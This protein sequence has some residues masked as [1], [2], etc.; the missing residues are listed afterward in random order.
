MDREA[1]VVVGA[2]Q[3]GAWAVRTLRSHGF[4]GRLVL[5]GD[6][7]APPYERPP[8]SKEQLQATP[9]MMQ[10]LM[11][12]EELDV[13]AIEWRPATSCTRIDRLTRKVELSNG[14]SIRYDQLILCT[15]GRARFPG[16][17]GLD[18]DRVHTLR[19]LEDAERLHAQL[20]R[21]ARLLVIGG[22]WIGL[23]VAASARAVGCAVTL[24]EAG[25]SLCT[26][27]GSPSLSAFLET[28]HLAN[29][30][31]LRLGTSVAAL[32]HENGACRVRFADGAVQ[33]TDIVVVGVG[34]EPNDALARKAGLACDRGILVDQQCRTSD[35]RIFAAGDVTVMR[36]ADG[37]LLRLESWQNA[38][39]QGAAAARAALGMD[40]AYRPVP[41]FWSQ[42]YDSLVQIAGL[43]VPGSQ[44]LVRVADADK[45]IAIELNDDNQITSVVCTNSPRD[46]RQLRKFV[47]EGTRVDPAILSDIGLPLATAEVSLNS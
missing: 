37:G 12:P 13:L 3:A 7:R 6:E 45:V 10:F 16:I 8:L 23:E 21:G 41:F 27:S 24:V 9:P 15:G 26:R 29:G 43:P 17:P 35:S 32:E 14:E 1:I 19:S 39:D 44:T 28:L 20:R 4:V 30:V 46:F 33:E 47:S 36:S 40:I 25:A 38:Q 5:I 18:S 22:G 31:D 34:L 2:G 11:P 42:Q